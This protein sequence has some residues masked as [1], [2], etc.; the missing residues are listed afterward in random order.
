MEIK[1]AI[2]MCKTIEEPPPEFADKWEALQELI[3]LAEQV[4]MMEGIADLSEA[5]LKKI[6][7]V[8]FNEEIGKEVIKRCNILNAYWRALTVGKLE[9]LTPQ[10]IGVEIKLA[11]G[12]S[13]LSDYLSEE[14][15][16]KVSTAIRNLLMGVAK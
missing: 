15:I 16:E 12:T 3:A 6:P 11:D 1:E 14:D 2:K 5:D 9:R 8:N 10:Y 7:L 4:E 13:M